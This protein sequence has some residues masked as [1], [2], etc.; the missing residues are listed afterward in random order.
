MQIIG[1]GMGEAYL[2]NKF[3]DQ[4]RALQMIGE[5][6]ALKKLRLLNSPMVDLEVRGVP[7]LQYFGSVVWNEAIDEFTAGIPLF[8]QQGCLQS[9]QGDKR[10]HTDTLALARFLTGQHMTTS[11][12]VSA[13]K[14]D[15]R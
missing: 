8:S 15:L 10:F 11:H 1:P 5:D 6:P 9:T 13:V 12:K 14:S 2:K 7:A 4:D 3:R